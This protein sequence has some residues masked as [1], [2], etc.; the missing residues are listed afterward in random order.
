MKKLNIVLGITGSIAAYKAIILAKL[1][2]NKSHNIKIVLTKSA[3]DFV[4]I[5][6]LKSLFPKRVF[7]FDELLGEDD[8]MLHIT[9]AKFADLVLIA[10]SSANMI[11]RLSCGI[12]DCLLSNICLATKA[13]IV[14]AP[15]MNK[16]MWENSLVQ[17]NIST[18]IQNE[19]IVLGPESGAQACGD[20]GYGRMLEPQKIAEY[21]SYITTEKLFSNKKFIITAG[22]T[23][24]NIDPIRFISNHSSG[25]MGFALAK[26]AFD[27]GATV[28][29][30]SGHTELSPPYGVELIKVYDTDQMLNA[31]N[32]NIKNT[33]I[34]VGAAAVSDYKPDFFSN[35]KIK[36]NDSNFNLKLI[37]NID[38]ISTVKKNHPN[39]FCLG[40]AAET[41]NFR[42]FG[43][44]KLDEKNLD[45]IA[46]NDVSN[47]KV[48]GKDQNELVVISKNNETHHLPSTSKE[49]IAIQLLQLVSQALDFKTN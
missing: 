22:P 6:T 45:M 44:K 1:L 48:F 46:I 39:I 21:L 8:E 42:E 3:A 49:Q 13:R 20:E 36:K 10:P 14:L 23:R 16:I 32:S 47:E 18:L 24:E 31:I 28:Q 5:L 11:A 15:A 25:K 7:S 38:L 12:S 2:E 9:L 27:M 43:A 41:T 33:D 29:L 17:K 30:I 34:F 19:F 37:K 4:S 26:A 35:E 40:F